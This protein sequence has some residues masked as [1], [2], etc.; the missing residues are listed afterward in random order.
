MY[1]FLNDNMQYSKSG[2][3]HAEINRLHLFEKNGVP[4][5]IVTRVFSMELSKIID[6]A[7]IDPAGFVNLFQYFCG[8]ADVPTQRFSLNEFSLPSNTTQ[9]RKDNQIQVFAQG[10][11][12]MI[13]YLRQGSDDISNIQYFDV[14][15]RT[16]KMVWW[17]VRGFKCLEQLFDWDGKIV[18]EQYYGPDGLV[19]IEKCHL[20]NRAGKEHLS[21][22]VLNYRNRD[23]VFNGMSALTRFF[24]DELNDN[25]EQ[26]VYICDRTVECDWAL[27][28]MQTPAF[29]VL[30]LHND[31]VADPSDMLHS[32]LNN[33][34]QNALMNWDKWD[35]VISSTPEQ[36]QDIEDRFGKAIPAFTIPV[37]FVTDE[38]LA[39]TH[40]A[41]G[42]RQKHL[43]V[44]V[45][46]LAPEKQQ[47]HSIQAFAQ[48]H[49]KFPDARLELWGYANGD[50]GKTFK[51][52][53]ADLGLTNVVSF[54]GY[55]H[56][57][58]AVYDRAQLGLL[59]SRAEGFSLMLLEAQSHGLPMVANDVKYGPS[60]IIDN[61][62]SGRLTT[63][64]DVQGLADAMLDLLGNQD[65]L[66][67]YSE[68]AYEN[69]K[70]YSEEAVFKQWQALLTYFKEKTDEAVEA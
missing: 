30:H 32:P 46:R 65:E 14:N 10:K 37:G 15:G 17:D 43:V 23:W 64:G 59:P 68:A 2:I 6:Q 16:L 19:H 34:Y 56:D 58:A 66:A 24:Y 48:V 45:A 5:K 44:H 53:A 54:K 36:S 63:D 70:R 33:N 49:Q 55:T 31:H 18:Q 25:G 40:Q 3:E 13:I 9:T 21:W 47:N 29:R 22:R 4:A 8:S 7:G 26:N 42:Q 35:A 62:V 38:Q 1:Y 57:I 11:M 20:L 41:F 60:D 51:Q 69:A 27:F 61:N 12:L 67:A 39:E 28:N 50:I 52:E